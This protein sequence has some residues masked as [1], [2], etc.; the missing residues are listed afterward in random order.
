MSVPSEPQIRNEQEIYRLSTER[1]AAAIRLL[2]RALEVET[3][4]LSVLLV[5][6][7]RIRDLNRTYRHIDQPTDVLAFP[8]LI[9]TPEAIRERIRQAAPGTDLPAVQLGDIVISTET[10]R[11]RRREEGLD[12]DQE[13]LLL[14]AHGLLHLLGHDHRDPDQTRRLFQLQ[15]ELLQ[16]IREAAGSEPILSEVQP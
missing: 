15:E 8:Q 6:D 13:L 1:Y 14:T 16:R 7:A 5:D 10:I 9:G 11:R 12:P 2:M 3:A 4:E